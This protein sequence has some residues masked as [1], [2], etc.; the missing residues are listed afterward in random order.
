MPKG[1]YITGVSEHTMAAEWKD[2]AEVQEWNGD[3]L[4]I[5]NFIKGINDNV[6]DDDLRRPLYLQW[7]AMVLKFGE[8]WGAER[9]SQDTKNALK[10]VEVGVGV[11]VTKW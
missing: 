4:S 10:S 5:K 9:V 3:V 1:L 7:R 8:R 2:S 11:A 6:H